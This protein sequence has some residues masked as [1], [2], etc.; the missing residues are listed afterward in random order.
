MERS[1]V[2][3]GNRDPRVVARLEKARIAAEIALAERNFALSGYTQ[4]STGHGLV[5]VAIDGEKR[6]MALGRDEADALFRLASL[7]AR[8][9]GRSGGW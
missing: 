7:A 9:A 8:P 3:I 2:F 5:A 1:R 6:L 4:P